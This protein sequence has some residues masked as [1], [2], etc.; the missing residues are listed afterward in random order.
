MASP[1]VTYGITVAVVVLMSLLDTLNNMELLSVTVKAHLIAYLPLFEQGMG[2][3]IPGIIA[4]I[5]SMFIGKFMAK[6][7]PIAEQNLA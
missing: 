2:W 3:L 6:D 5:L 4:F 7:E 1:R